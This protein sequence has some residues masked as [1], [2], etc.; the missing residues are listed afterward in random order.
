MG[1]WEI[2]S[3]DGRY[4][5]KTKPLA[6]IFSEGA[7]IRNRVLVELQWL[8]FLSSEIKV[9]RTFDKDRQ[10]I[11]NFIYN[12]VD[13]GRIKDIEEKTN[14]DVKAVE[15]YIKEELEVLGWKKITEWVHFACTSED[16]SNCAYAYML[17]QGR[18]Y[19][20]RQLLHLVNRIIDLSIYYQRLPMMSRTHGQP[21][22]P[23]TVGKEFAIYAYRLI[24]L[25][26]E[27]DDV[28]ITVKFNGATGNF[29]AHVIAL[30][31]VNWI[32]A[33]DNFITNYLGFKPIDLS[34][35]INNYSSFAK[36]LHVISRIAD[37]ITDLDQD[38]WQY[39]SL[40]YF[41]QL[42]K[43]GEVGSSTM[44]HKVNPIDFENG[45]GN[46]GFC[47]AN[48]NH[49]ASKLLKSRMQRDLTDSTALRNLGSIFAYLLIGIASTAKGLGKIE[50]NNEKI[51][52]DLV[53]R[54]ELLTEPIQ[55]VMRM[56]GESNPYE[57]LK[58]LS[59]GQE[60]NQIDVLNFI[61]TLKCLPDERI[62][63]LRK[64]N[65]SDYT[66]LAFELVNKFLRKIYPQ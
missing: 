2:T 51:A 64:L 34:T 41:R 53:A 44:P 1:V 65:P 58:E 38:M 18:D 66:G 15:Y 30:P 25:M 9:F 6:E 4:G 42:T 55:T 35:Q 29:N 23:T 16:I 8:F 46:L 57:R 21:A 28:E 7:L 19:I 27:L 60:I 39:I 33:S 50:I 45:E 13:V 14:H 52:A 37:T 43:K 10:E 24:E 56:F 40:G 48:A 63:V 12:Q 31:D 36:M 61:D 5:K 20:Y 49:L 17:D 47:V 59:R 62:R 26:N 11:F 54:Y 32:E 3:I 22:S